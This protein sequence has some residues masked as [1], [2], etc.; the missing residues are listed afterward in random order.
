[1]YLSISQ[2]NY[3]LNECV[4]IWAGRYKFYDKLKKQVAGYA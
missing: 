2:N 1:M 4:I 3:F